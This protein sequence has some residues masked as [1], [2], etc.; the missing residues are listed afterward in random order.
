MKKENRSWS[1]YL[2]ELL[3][4]IIGITIAFW[5]SNLAESSNNRKQM[6]TYLSDIKNDLKTD[7]IRLTRN[8]RNNEL[9]SK[10]LLKSLEFIKQ[11]ASIDSVLVTVLQI[12]EYDFFKPD[13]FTLTSLIQSG[14]L[15]LIESKETKRELLRLLKMYD[16][17]EDMQNN[18]LDALDQNYFPMLLSRVD[19]TVLEAIDPNFFYG[20]EI[21]NYAAFALN[22]TM[23]HIKNYEYTLSQVT[24]TI[25]LLELEIND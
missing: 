7:S 12:G 22:E 6:T 20:I 8:I 3:I 25:Q 11:T 19:M 5:L 17:V 18:F 21:K 10:T 9:K 24:K 2:I 16:S 23:R 15:K 13:N 4:V 1:N 14:D